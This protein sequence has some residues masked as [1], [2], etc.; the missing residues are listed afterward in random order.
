M[1][2]LLWVKLKAWDTNIIEMTVVNKALLPETKDH[3]FIKF[4]VAYASIK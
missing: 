2:M 1:A 3:F 4:I